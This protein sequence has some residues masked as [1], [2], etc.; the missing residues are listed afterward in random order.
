MHTSYCAAMLTAVKHRPECRICIWL[1]RRWK[2]RLSTALPP[3]VF[4]IPSTASTT[5][6]P[7][8][9]PRFHRFQNFVAHC[10]P[11]FHRVPIGTVDG[12]SWVERWRKAGAAPPEIPCRCCRRKV[13]H[14]RG[15]RTHHAI[16]QPKDG[17]PLRCAGPAGDGAWPTCGYR[18]PRRRRC[19]RSWSRPGGATPLIFC[20]ARSTSGGA[21]AQ[22][23]RQPNGAIDPTCNCKS[24]QPGTDEWAWHGYR[25]RGRRRFHQSQY[26][27]NS[28]HDGNGP[29]K[30]L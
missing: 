2:D 10:F 20:C 4:S 12:G 21:A 7:S 24:G 11:P 27:A 29:S 22:L 30:Q 5:L 15:S 17:V 8:V 23:S 18:H 1:L 25:V 14:E 9:P 28:H 26:L 6:P 13:L 3:S 19:A 16:V